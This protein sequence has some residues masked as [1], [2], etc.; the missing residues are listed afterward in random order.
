VKALTNRPRL[1]HGPVGMK[2]A[3]RRPNARRF[4]LDVEDRR[5]L[6][7]RIVLIVRIAVPSVGPERDSPLK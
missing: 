4:L 5:R 6:L 7:E 3:V 2:L 1:A